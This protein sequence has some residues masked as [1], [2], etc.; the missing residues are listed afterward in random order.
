MLSVQLFLINK[1]LDVIRNYI[2]TLYDYYVNEET[3]EWQRWEAQEWDYPG[4]DKFKFIWTIILSANVINI[5]VHSSTARMVCVTI[6]VVLFSIWFVAFVY[7]HIKSP[8]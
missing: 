4:I 1:R 3:Y 5:I 8:L 6:K 7:S 2:E